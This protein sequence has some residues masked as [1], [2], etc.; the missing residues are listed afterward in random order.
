L[1]SHAEV[2]KVI[3]TEDRLR[4]KNAEEEEGWITGT[5]I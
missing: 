5:K 2:K 3:L 1:F 4:N